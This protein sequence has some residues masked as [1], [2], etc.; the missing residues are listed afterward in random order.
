MG[1]CDQQLYFKHIQNAVEIADELAIVTRLKVWLI[2]I[3][4]RLIIL[5]LRIKCRLSIYRLP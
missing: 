2:Y 1:D 4:N 3:L 5:A